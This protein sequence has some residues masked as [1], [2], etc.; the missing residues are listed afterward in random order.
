MSNIIVDPVSM[1]RYSIY[2]ARGKQLL[3][4]YVYHVQNGGSGGGGSKP[5]YYINTD[6]GGGNKQCSTDICGPCPLESAAC[7]INEY[8]FGDMVK[9]LKS[10]PQTTWVKHI[11][12]VLENF[13]YINFIE[14]FGVENSWNGVNNNINCPWLVYDRFFSEF[15]TPNELMVEFI[16]RRGKDA[17][18][19]FKKVHTIIA[20]M[21][22][23]NLT[24]GDA[25]N[26]I[27]N[28]VQQCGVLQPPAVPRAQNL[29][30][31]RTLG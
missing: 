5:S 8:K 25:A 19:W 18:E 31:E 20:A 12:N 28:I 7:S 1:N 29:A 9:R 3:K 30:S 11:T 4:S 22:I 27:Y 17:M 24:G 15:I 23:L 13:G 6:G 10:G 16:R 21:S 14:L 26:P 2:S